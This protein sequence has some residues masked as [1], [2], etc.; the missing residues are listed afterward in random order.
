GEMSSSVRMSNAPL[1]GLVAKRVELR[2]TEQTRTSVPR[3][4]V[5]DLQLALERSSCVLLVAKI[6]L[7]AG[8]RDME[9]VGRGLP[10]RVDD[11]NLDIA[12]QFSHGGTDVI[13]QPG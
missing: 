2:S 5:D 11:R 12:A 6:Q 3:W 10:L 9:D 8:T 13:K 1:F 4:V 7:G